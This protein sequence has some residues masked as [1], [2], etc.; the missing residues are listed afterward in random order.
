MKWFIRLHIA[1]LVIVVSGWVFW[2]QRMII[3]QGSHALA[4]GE[5]DFFGGVTAILGCGLALILTWYKIDGSK[6]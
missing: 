1:L 6:R 3:P 4:V 5:S 2:L